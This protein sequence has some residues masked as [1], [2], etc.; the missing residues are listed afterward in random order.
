MSNLAFFPTQPRKSQMEDSPSLQS[1]IALADL[2]IGYETQI[3][4][5][6]QELKDLTSLLKAVS[7][8]SIPT[9]METLGM[10]DFT[11]A[12]GRKLTIKDFYAGRPLS[13]EAFNWLKENGYGDMVKAKVIIPY[14]F[15]DDDELT[16]IT[17][18]LEEADI[19]YETK[20]EIHHMTFGAFLREQ[21]S[22]ELTLP[23]E[24]FD[25]YH[26]QKTHIK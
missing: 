1:L 18:P 12:N 19:T 15:T 23:S 8:H 3:V 25:V 20:T 24:L 5:L 7:E 11:L 26:G 6:Q 13:P 10:K 22:K 4:D 2:Q 21:A 17:G 14:D 9:M 16:E